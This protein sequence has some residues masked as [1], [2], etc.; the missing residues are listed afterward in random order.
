[1]RKCKAWFARFYKDQQGFVSIFMILWMTVLLPMLLFVGLDLTQF[2]YENTRT[3]TVIDNASA[4]AVTRLNEDVIREGI[5]KIDEAKATEVAER[6]I[7]EG[8]HLDE[9]LEPLEGSPLVSK[10][11]IDVQV[12]N[13]R[14]KNGYPVDT[15][16]GD[17][18]VYEPSVVIYAEYPVEGLFFTNDITLEKIGASQATFKTNVEE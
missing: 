17:V 10:P 4:S 8:L 12:V 6:I 2:I 11:T 9:N 5:L 16:T 14:N 7:R 18:M 13:V 1:M 3:K 15:P